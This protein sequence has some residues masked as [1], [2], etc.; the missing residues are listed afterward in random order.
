MYHRIAKVFSILLGV[1]FLFSALAKISFSREKIEIFDF[2]AGLCEIFLAVFLF[3][4][5]YLGI[6]WGIL[7][8]IA[9]GWM[10]YSLYW[11][12]QGLSCGCLGRLILFSPFV[13][14]FL[15][16]F[17]LLMS[18]FL[19]FNL[20]KSKKIYVLIFIPISIVV[21]FCFASIINN[22]FFR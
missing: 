13:S 7:T 2:F 16:L 8:L 15:D 1:F 10:G 19:F 22:Y 18:L 3:V 11:A 5:P 9:S 17:I 14:F 4:F 12:I 20:Y 6:L 21:G